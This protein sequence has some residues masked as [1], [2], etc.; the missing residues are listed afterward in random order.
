MAYLSCLQKRIAPNRLP[1]MRK[2]R[3]RGPAWGK[4][5]LILALVAFT[6]IAR[7]FLAKRLASA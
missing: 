2:R 7:H 1:A 4:L 5:A 6:F 3:G